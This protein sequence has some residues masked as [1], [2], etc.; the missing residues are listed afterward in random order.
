MGSHPR[1][2]RAQ[3]NSPTRDD[4][5]AVESGEPA[6]VLAALYA[7]DRAEHSGVPP[8]GTPEYR[9]LRERDRERRVRADAALA[10]LRA[11]GRLS[12]DAAFH[13]AWLFNHG[14]LADEAR[15]AHD[16]ARGAALAGHSG[17]RWLAAAAFDRCCMY[18]GRP[19]KYGTQFV[20]DGER[21]RLWDVD[22]STTDAERASWNVPP[23]GEQLRRADELSRSEPQPP[24]TDAPAWL[25]DAIERWR[26]R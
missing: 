18:E 4:N 10:K 8:V 11:S 9:R 20:P 22:P 24:M 21:Y 17:A 25:K 26:G 12:A 5:N 1:R 16:L 3:V 15:Q 2:A 6:T 13:A 19:Q 14:D 7:E 23:L